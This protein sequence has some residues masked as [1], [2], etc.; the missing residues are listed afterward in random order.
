MSHI[1]P[2]ANGRRPLSGTTESPWRQAWTI[3]EFCEAFR[4]SR[5][6]VYK[7]ANQGRIRT[8]EVAGRRLIPDSERQRLLE[9]GFTMSPIRKSRFTK[10]RR[11]AAASNEAAQRCP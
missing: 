10:Q 9:G 6:G 4:I 5:S 7:M 8:I 1:Q 2:Q 11:V 3:R